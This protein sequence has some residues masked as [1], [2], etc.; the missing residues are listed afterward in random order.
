MTAKASERRQHA[1]SRVLRRGQVVLRGG[2]STIGCVVLD[3]SAGGALI[4]V[5]DWLR[6]P[7][8]FELRLDNG[9]SR[10]AVVCFRDRDTAGIAFRDAPPRAAGSLRRR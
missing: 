10:L 2:Y 3:L 7:D 6:L 5:S 4:R 9:Q 8:A 1:R